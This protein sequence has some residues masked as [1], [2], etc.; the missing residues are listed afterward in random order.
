MATSHLVGGISSAGRALPLLDGRPLFVARSAGPHVW[1]DAGA[2]YIDT[3]L[4]FGATALG[5]AH[6]AVVEAVGRALANGPMPAFAH[7]TEEAAAAALTEATGELSRVVFTSTG[8]EAVHLACRIARIATGRGTVAKMAAGFDGWYDDVAF[9]NAGSP[10]AAMQANARPTR[11]RTTLLR[12][13]DF[14]D[15]EMLFAESGDIAAVLLEPMLANAGCIMPAPG[16][17]AHVEKIARRH[18]AVVILDEVLTG[19]RTRFGLLGP[20]WGITPDLATVGKAIGSGIAVAGVIGTPAIMEACE[21]GRAVRAGTYSGNTIATAAVTAT[22][23][24]LRELDFDALLGRGERLRAA[25]A[26]GFEDAGIAVSTSGLGTVFSTWFDRDQPASY[27]EAIRKA[28]ARRSFDLHLKMRRRG[29]LTM[30][31]PFGRIFL[32]AAHDEAVVSELAGMF[33]GAALSMAETA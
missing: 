29:A 9:G 3:V 12:F 26:A 33:A 11:G 14:E 2:R 22:M 8:S 25:I 24:I 21:R 7:R 17:L 6:P 5:H 18:G 30:P 4:G 31:S 1:D 13:N 19:F 10:E 15:A 16:Y 20:S 23:A 27:A 28:D 32:S